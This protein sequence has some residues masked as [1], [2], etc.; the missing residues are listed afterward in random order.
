MKREAD[1]N[2]ALSDTARLRA[3][4]LTYRPGSRHATD[5]RCRECREADQLTIIK[6]LG[7]AT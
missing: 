5:C 7:G 6:R 4:P 3:L 2:R 1:A